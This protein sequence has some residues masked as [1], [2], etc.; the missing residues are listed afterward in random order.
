MAEIASAPNADNGERIKTM[1]AITAAVILGVAAVLTAW[2]AYRESLVSDGVLRG[3][4][5]QQALITQANDTYGQSDAERSL[6]EQ[7]FLQY[8]IQSATGNEAAAVYL[9]QTMSTEMWNAVSWWAEQDDSGPVSPFVPENPYF[10]ELASQQLLV[11]GDELMAQAD[12]KR[13]EAETADSVSDRFGLANV[14]FAIVLF[15]AG[16]ATLLSRVKVQLGVLILSV[17]M[18]I[19]GIVVLVTTPTWSSL[20]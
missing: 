16:V 10:T 8:A 15:L 6:E 17:A 7:F 4:S 12:V 13:T 1:L 11:Q 5:E 18:L 14:F 9:E 3:Y 19:G 20:S 2:G